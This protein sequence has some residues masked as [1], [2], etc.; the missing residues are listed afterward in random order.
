MDGQSLRGK[1]ALVCGASRGIG[2]A[3]A[4]ALAARGAAVT[5]LAR[6][7]DRLD[8]LLPQLVAAGAERAQRV[9]ADLDERPALG[10]SVAELVARDPVH[11]L[12]LCTGGPKG[13]PMLDASDEALVQSFGRNVLAGN[14]LVR[15]VLPGMRAAG[16]GRIV[17]VLSTSAREPIEN[18]G[19]GNTIRAAMAGWAK[20]LSAELPP[21]VTINNVLPGYTA[22]DR[23]RELAE[24]AAI[25]TGRTVPEVEKTW[26]D[27]IPERRLAAPSEI[28]EVIAFLCAPAASYLRGQSI[29]VD[30]GRM[31]G[32]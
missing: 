29:A 7:R 1:H 28:G 13:G 11:M 17:T 2:Q 20:T 9:V 23:L 21:G 32:I 22:T 6:D 27:A 15:T 14:L 25:R 26:A 19:V 10:R 3:A 12:V 5:G 18:L 16:Y 31:R 4:M 8:A 24:G 30:G